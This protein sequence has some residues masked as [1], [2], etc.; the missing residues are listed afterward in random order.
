MGRGQADGR[1]GSCHQDQGRGR[2]AQEGARHPRD[3]ARQSPGGAGQG[4]SGPEGGSG[5]V[6]WLCGRRQGSGGASL[7]DLWRDE[8]D[9]GDAHDVS[10]LLPLIE[11]ETTSTWSDLRFWCVPT[12]GQVQQ[13][14]GTAL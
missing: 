4:T 10:S 3:G 8:G 6:Q 7:E 13:I 5:G 14:T 12:A 2:N 9:G 11:N 1:Q